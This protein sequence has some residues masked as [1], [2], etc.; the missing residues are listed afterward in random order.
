MG[1]IPPILSNHRFKKSPYFVYTS[2]VRKKHLVG[3]DL[4]HRK[5]G[6]H[7]ISL[8]DECPVENTKPSP[9]ISWIGGPIIGDHGI[10]KCEGRAIDIN[11]LIGIIKPS[12]SQYQRDFIIISSAIWN[13]S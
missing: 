7:V 13:C 3:V 1:I 2:C 5:I 11:R 12:C 9:L 10:G 4:K 8:L 6:K